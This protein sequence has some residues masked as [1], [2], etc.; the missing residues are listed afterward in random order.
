[1]KWVIYI[2]IILLII[3]TDQSLFNIFHLGR[4]TPDLLLLFTL[5]T[6][7]SFNNF[8]FLI[9]ALLGG[10]WLEVLTGLP[11]GSLILSL[12][13]VGSMAYLIINR[14]LFSEKSW[15]YFFGAVIIGTIFIHAWLWLYTGLLT[16]FDWSNVLIT[17]KIILRGLL[18]AL[19]VNVALTYPILVITELLAKVVQR[20][21]S[22]G[23]ISGSGQSQNSIYKF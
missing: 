1:M 6:V 8:D 12:I 21:N 3:I 14:W 17:G 2:L 18:P 19:L 5:A 13:I 23:R 15:Q 7:W 9:F 4:Y 10:F 20:S 22:S 11:V 16:V